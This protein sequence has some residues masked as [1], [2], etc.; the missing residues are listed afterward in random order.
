MWMTHSAATAMQPHQ[1]N[2]STHIPAG[3]LQALSLEPYLV[4]C[5]HCHSGGWIEELSGL[6]HGVHNDSKLSCNS[7]SRSFESDPL[8]ELKAPSSQGTLF[9]TAREVVGTQRRLRMM[10]RQSQRPRYTRTCTMLQ[11]RALNIRRVRWRFE[12][13]SASCASAPSSSMRCAG[14]SANLESS[15]LKDHP[16]S[17]YGGNPCLN[18][19]H[20]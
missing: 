10:Q 14:T 18:L 11:S 2:G 3:T 15:L 5:Y 9:G 4:L 16:I 12:R 13:T 7:H 20:L 19:C 6:E 1:R 17:L 8:P